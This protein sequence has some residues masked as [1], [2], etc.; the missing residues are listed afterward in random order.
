MSDKK[1]IESVWI[2]SNGCIESGDYIQNQN[3]M[4]VLSFT[5]K[6][7]GESARFH[8][9]SCLLLKGMPA[10]TPIE[11]NDIGEDS[12]KISSRQK[13]YGNIHPLYNWSKFQ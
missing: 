5:C 8:W 9:A 7:K 12:K 6:D 10:Y 1:R 11:K 3:K 4:N 13:I 2:N